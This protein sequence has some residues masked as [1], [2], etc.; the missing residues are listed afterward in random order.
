[1]CCR[2]RDGRTGAPATR[3]QWVVELLDPDTRAG[4]RFALMVL[5]AI[6]L[7]TINV[8]LQSVEAINRSAGPALGSLTALFNLIFTIEYAL[9]CYGTVPCSAYVCSFFGVIDLLAVLPGP[10]DLLVDIAGGKVCVPTRMRGMYITCVWQCLC[11]CC[12]SAAASVCVCVCVRVRGCALC[13]E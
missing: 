8:C 13:A 4:R 11:G 10:L 5:A 7:S 6:V 9:R 12:V 2:S 1:M 3:S